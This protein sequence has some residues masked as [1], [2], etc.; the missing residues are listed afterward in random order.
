MNEYILYINNKNKTKEQNINIIKNILGP[1]YLDAIYNIKL[2]TSNYPCN[3]YELDQWFDLT[4]F[5]SYD[6]QLAYYVQI[7]KNGYNDIYGCCGINNDILN[8]VY[9]T[10]KY[11]Y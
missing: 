1:N 4:Y 6:E 10:L 5:D 3:L 8:D 7:W 11:I 2:Y 9:N